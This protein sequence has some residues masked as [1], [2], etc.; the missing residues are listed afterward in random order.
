MVSRRSL[1]GRCLPSKITRHAVRCTTIH[2]LRGHASPTP[3]HQRR[4][5]VLPHSTTYCIFRPETRSLPLPDECMPSSQLSVFPDRKSF[6]PGGST[7][8]HVLE[9]AAAASFLTDHARFA[10]SGAG[11][12][13]VCCRQSVPIAVP[14]LQFPGGPA[15]RAHFSRS[16]RGCSETSE[17]VRPACGRQRARHESRID[18]P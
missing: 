13:P 18:V 5:L 3:C 2:L 6:L 16:P 1:F 9:S 8:Q 4:S 14:S 11:I 17:T 7:H 15:S 12:S 10:S